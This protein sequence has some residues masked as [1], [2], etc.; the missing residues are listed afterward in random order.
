MLG[1]HQCYDQQAVRDVNV[2]FCFLCAGSQNIDVLFFFFSDNVFSKG[3][4][5]KKQVP[6]PAVNIA[7]SL[8]LKKVV[9]L[10][11]KQTRLEG[12]KYFFFCVYFVLFTARSAV[13]VIV[14]PFIVQ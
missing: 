8:W 1:S 2:N 6:L 9:P 13:S 4:K 10:M 7:F 11:T 12:K 3:R 14:F 5:L